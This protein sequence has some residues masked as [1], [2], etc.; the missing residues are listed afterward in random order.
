MG[1]IN[2]F[3]FSIANEL[4]NDSLLKSLFNNHTS[5]VLVH[6]AVIFT[7][8]EQLG[9]SKYLPHQNKIWIV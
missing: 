2:F 7:L 1:E 6:S 9:L 8:A 3:Q 5:Y 4:A